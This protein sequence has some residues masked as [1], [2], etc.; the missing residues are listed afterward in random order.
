M[1][2]DCLV[3]DLYSRRNS[4]DSRGKI[5]HDV[6]GKIFRRRW[7]WPHVCYQYVPHIAVFPP[8]SSRNRAFKKVGTDMHIV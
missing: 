3:L 7:R 8:R 2:I 5:A 6:G 1:G 4:A